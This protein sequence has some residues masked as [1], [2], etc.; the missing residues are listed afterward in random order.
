MSNSFPSDVIDIG[1]NL[2][3]SAFDADRCD[4]LQ[5]AAMAGVASMIVTGTSVA[6]SRA[7]V[8]LA[9]RTGLYAT[10]GVHPHDAETAE[11]DWPDAIASLAASPRV[12]AIGETGLD[13]YRNYSSRAAQRRAFQRQAELAVA[14]G[15]PLFVHDRDSGGETRAILADY[16]DS[17]VDCVIH[18]FTGSA[19]DLD[20]YLQ[21]GYHIGVTGWICDPR[22]GAELA[23]LAMRIPAHRLM[24][25]TDAPF[26]LPR[27]MTPKP[28]SRRNE[29][30]FLPWVVAKLAECR[31][32]EA[33]TLARRTHANAARFF[34]I[35]VA[36]D[37]ASDVPGHLRSPDV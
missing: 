33:A 4:V 23:A 20:G 29:P 10:A 25:E 5:R 34:R 16:R 31:G 13:Y 7:A 15:K 37:V 24:I 28:R 2:T 21:D 9:E 3:H 18:C 36:S 8:V 6:T 27:N 22:R 26:L 32:E 19:E 35:D 12:V 1:V 30:A 17:L 14:V 11:A